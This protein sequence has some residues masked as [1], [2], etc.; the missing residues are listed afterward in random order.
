MLRGSTNTPNSITKGLLSQ[1]YE[2][3]IGRDSG[4]K[5]YGISIRLDRADRQGKN[6]APAFLILGF[7]FAKKGIHKTP[8]KGNSMHSQANF[9]LNSSLQRVKTQNIFPH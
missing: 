2:L 9:N 6:T 3:S 1:M 7:I 5:R 8:M 4:L